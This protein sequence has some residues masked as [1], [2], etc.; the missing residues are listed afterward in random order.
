VWSPDGKWLIVALD[1]DPVG[2]EGGLLC[3]RFV[4]D[5]DLPRA[6]PGDLEDLQA[7]VAGDTTF[8]NRSRIG[9]RYDPEAFDGHERLA[10]L[11]IEQ[12]TVEQVISRQIERV[13]D[14]RRVIRPV[15]LSQR[16]KQV[17]A[18]S[19]LTISEVTRKVPHEMQLRTAPWPKKAAMAAE[20]SHTIILKDRVIVAS[21]V[22]V[23]TLDK[24]SGMRISPQFVIGAPCRHLS[25]PEGDPEVVLAVGAE[26]FV[27]E[28]ATM[29]CMSTF[30]CLPVF[31]NFRIVRAD[32]V[33]AFG[34]GRGW[35]Y[36]QSAKAWVGG[37]LVKSPVDA[38]MAEVERLAAWEP[39]EGATSQWFNF[40]ITLMNA[41]YSG[42]EDVAR[43]HLSRMAEYRESPIARDFL[44]RIQATLANQWGL[45]PE[46]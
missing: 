32:L 40:E 28:I 8:V 35:I 33:L 45:I 42:T 37:T 1:S 13:V 44:N 39:Y 30:S 36:D 4:R 3:V 24:S 18:F 6:D 46:I 15:L 17:I 29:K 41:V 7:R 11:E 31:Y 25:V 16:E 22:V 21:D 34:R 20:P 2:R 9:R 12:L 23:F 38:P 26:C 27:L 10:D 14:G 19:C 43:D 5:F